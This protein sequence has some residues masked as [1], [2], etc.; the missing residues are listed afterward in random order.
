MYYGGTSIS[1]WSLAQTSFML[2]NGPQWN[3]A[4][5][6]S[7]LF[8]QLLRQQHKCVTSSTYKDFVYNQNLTR[9]FAL[10]LFFTSG[11]IS[12]LTFQVKNVSKQR[13]FLLHSKTRYFVPVSFTSVRKI[14]SYQILFQ[15]SVIFRQKNHL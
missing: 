11:K 14:I 4:K 5:F 2:L 12:Q 3:M 15:F 9:K 13:N 10:Q 7:T 6:L 1:K 8:Y